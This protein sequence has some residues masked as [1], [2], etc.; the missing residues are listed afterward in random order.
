[1]NRIWQ[2]IK[3][4]YY[5]NLYLAAAH[6]TFIILLFLGYRIRVYRYI[7]S[8]YPDIQIRGLGEYISLGIHYDSLA[9]FFTLLLFFMLI[10]LLGGA[11]KIKYILLSLISIIFIFFMLFGIEFFRVYETT[12]QTN[13]AGREQLS[14]LRLV[15]ESALA[16]FSTEFY[17]LLLTLSLVIIAINYLFGGRMQ[18]RDSL[19]ADEMPR[20]GSATRL[21]QI[22]LPSVLLL[23]LAAGL[24][25]EPEIKSGKFI[26][27][28]RKE[29]AGK[30][31]SLLH[32][33]SMNPAYNLV[34]R[35]ATLM[36]QQQQTNETGSSNVPFTFKLNTDSIFHARRYKRRDIIP[37]GKRYNIILYF[38]ESTPYKYYDIKVRG[39]QVIP[40]WH[41]LEKN[42]INFR[43]HYVNYPLSANAL[44]SVFASAYDL[45][46]PDLLIQ[47]YPKIK[48]ITLPEILKDRGYRTCLIHSGGLGYAG[49][50]R[51]LERRKFDAIYDYNYLI[52]IE[53]YNRQVGWGVDERAMIKPGIEFIK[54]D[55]ARPYLV[56]FM[57]VN[58]HHPYAIPGKQFQI[59]GD[60]PEDIDS[61]KRS[62]L[63]Y[64]NSLHY[65]DASLG[66]LVDELDKE[67]L[68]DDT[69]LFIFADHGEAFYQH[70]RNYNHPLYLYN[71][72]VHVPFLI[73]N[74]KIF[75]APLYFDGIT[76]HIDILPTIRDILGIPPVP[77]EEGIPILAPH[78][79]QLALLHTSWKDDYM[80]IADGNWKYI[81][82][83]NDRL[84]ELYDL[85][86]DP[87]E[88]N[89]VAST[90]TDIVERYRAYVL[91][92]RRYKDDYYERIL[93][94]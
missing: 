82:R 15:I 48:L 77:E 87:N 20:H 30:Y 43:H 81:C 2:K 68:L 85:G 61:R 76:R 93:K 54:K 11:G 67:A 84:E 71:E 28:Y 14:G 91:K 19:H 24:A 31:I 9:I 58:P 56:V 66:M 53:P 37:R 60:I 64:L 23:F 79:E 51:F 36:Q 5:S 26:P 33:F 45:N 57:P 29:E 59:T 3:S 16:E 7:R 72:N 25:T 39:R 8:I 34:T 83:T 92:A 17:V 86:K 32:E 90:H 49:Q 1:M 27:R 89:N 74:K 50:R 94:R 65:A 21:I 88:K 55:A 18:S 69:L 73:Y 41:R 40:A 80:G 42:S 4:R 10:L 70:R 13:F 38:F 47:K 63:N 44:I 6:A 46:T 78:R 75:T 62:W 35:E 52:K 12:F 22:F